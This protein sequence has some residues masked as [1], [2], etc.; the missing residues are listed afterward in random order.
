MSSRYGI[1]YSWYVGFDPDVG[2]YRFTRNTTSR[3]A[4][5]IL[6]L[7][8]L[9]LR[10]LHRYVID[11]R[12]A[13]GAIGERVLQ[14]V[15]IVAVRE[16]RPAVGPARLPSVQRAVGDR[17]RDVEHEVEFEHPGHL[18]VE[19]AVL[20]RHP[21]APEAIPE[22]GE[23][24]A[25]VREA[26]FV[27]EDPD[28]ALHE[29]LHLDADARQR[30]LPPLP[31][32]Q[33]VED[34]G[35]LLPQRLWRRRSARIRG[36]LLRVLCRREA[37][38]LAEHEA[39]AQ[40]VRP[41]AV[42]PVDRDARGLADCVEAGQRGLARGIR[43]NT[44][45]DVMLPGAHRDRLVNRIESHVLLRELADHRELLVDR[46]GAEVT[47][48]Q[49]EVLPVRTVERAARLHLLDHRAGEDVPRPELHLAREVA[50]HVPLAVLVD[51]VA[52][53]PASRLGDQDPRPR[54]ARRM[55][56]H[57]LHILEGHA[58][59]VGEGHAV[60][61]LDEAVR[62]EFV[63]PAA[64]ARR[65]DRRLPADPHHPAAAKVE[66]GHPGARAA[67][68]DKA[69]D[70]VLVEAVDVLE[71]HGRL[72]ERVQ[73]VEADLVRREHGALDGHPAERALAHPAVR[74][75]GPG[76]APVLELDDL[77][78][79]PRDEELDGVLVGEE[80]GSLDRVER[81]QFQGIVIA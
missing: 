22:L 54:Q 9:P 23:F 8:G 37:T 1:R 47:E 81:V 7:D 30:L 67:V 53:L 80:V 25:R 79:T 73:D 41:E 61:G 10:D 70:E 69:R 49:A 36:L 39:F 32:H 19:D 56:L 71:L 45:H 76:T 57:H 78:R 38:P 2:R 46:R 72:E 52:A 51:Q 48:V 15:R 3:S 24:S 64:A 11:P 77:L 20:V 35:F 58:G 29:L 18:R 12:C 60:A 31:A 42:R 17:R 5:S 74:I 4:I 66:R 13:V 63:H 43:R 50:L 55:E 33:A 59:T 21:D 28:V 40:A 26:G 68:D 14:V 34:A 27:P 65:E 16:V 75:A 44:A 6:P 62:R